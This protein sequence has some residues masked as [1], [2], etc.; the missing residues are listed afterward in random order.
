MEMGTYYK[1][2]FFLFSFSLESWLFS[3]KQLTTVEGSNVLVSDEEA[4]KKEVR[5]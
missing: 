1:A 3:I 2:G 5:F 4:K